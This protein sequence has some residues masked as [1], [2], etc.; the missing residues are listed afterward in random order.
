MKPADGNA[1]TAMSVSPWCGA[2][3]S[4]ADRLC[5]TYQMRLLPHP[6]YPRTTEEPFADRN[7]DSK[8][9]P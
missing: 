4:A 2:V 6:V 5:P 8:P 1:R 3:R 7:S 9:A